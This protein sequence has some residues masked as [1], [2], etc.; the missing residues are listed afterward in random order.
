MSEATHALMRK[1][2]ESLASAKADLQAG[3]LNG[4]SSRAYYAMFHA[5]RAALEMRGI[6][7]GGQRHG[8]I[9]GRF[10]RTFVKNGP[11]DP[12]LGRALNKTLELRREGDYDLA[13]PDARDVGVALEAAE[14]LVDAIA[15]ICAPGAGV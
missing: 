12:A 9:I 5:A 6:A 8:T 2:R 15:E 11:L 7:T 1:A 14:A 10:G 4:A 3:R 13:S